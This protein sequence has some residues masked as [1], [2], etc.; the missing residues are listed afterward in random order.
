MPG[1]FWNNS[2]KRSYW[3]AGILNGLS[4]KGSIESNIN[5]ATGHHTAGA[6]LTGISWWFIIALL[7][8]MSI[9]WRFKHFNCLAFLSAVMF[10]SGISLSTHLFILLLTLFKR[11]VKSIAKSIGSDRFKFKRNSSLA[12]NDLDPST[13]GTVDTVSR[14]MCSYLIIFIVSLTIV[15]IAF[16]TVKSA[17]GPNSN[18]ALARIM[19]KTKCAFG[20][21]QAKPTLAEE[22]H[23]SSAYATVQYQAKPTVEDAAIQ[24]TKSSSN[25]SGRRWESACSLFGCTD[26]GAHCGRNTRLWRWELWDHLDWQVWSGF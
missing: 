16:I 3:N 5:N 2:R 11:L 8:R 24:S 7:L 23:H 25:S 22:S 14:R 4:R 13:S 6:Q 12:W 20:K 17:L 10:I 9:K 26:V 1:C 15:S 19:L 21:H 18:M